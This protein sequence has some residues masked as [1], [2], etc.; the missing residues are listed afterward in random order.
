[1]TSQRFAI[2]ATLALLFLALLYG[3]QH[4]ET[5]NA[6]DHYINAALGPYRFKVSLQALLWITALGANPAVF[7]VSVTATAFLWS[8]REFRFIGGLW[9]SFLGEQVTSWAFKY[10]VDRPRP[11]FLDI[12]SASSPSFPSGH[13]A[14]AMTVYGLFALALLTFPKK[15]GTLLPVALAV[16]IALIG[17]SRVFLSLHYMT[18][19]FGGFLIGGI[20]VIVGMG[21]AQGENELGSKPALERRR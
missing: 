12:A 17:F 11:Q 19:V 5:I 8:L 20:W 10:L 3:V 18:D 2:V 16:L 4:S 14:S 7:A 13:S 21:I 15:R 9:T 1:M 6:A